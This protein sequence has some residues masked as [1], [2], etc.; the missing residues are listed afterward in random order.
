V[1]EHVTEIGSGDTER[2]AWWRCSC[3]E[4]R[5]RFIVLTAAGPTSALR[6]ARIEAEEHAANPPRY[7]IREQPPSDLTWA[8]DFDV[9]FVVW[10]TVNDRRVSFGNYK[11]RAQAEAR[12]TRLENKA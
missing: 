1:S 5:L 2:S 7:V 9:I 10:D 3:D 4:R 6:L 11:D 12:I 8:F